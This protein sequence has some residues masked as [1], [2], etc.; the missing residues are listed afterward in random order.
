MIIR[1]QDMVIM[2]NILITDLPQ[3]DHQYHDLSQSW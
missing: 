1:R 2:K 3:L